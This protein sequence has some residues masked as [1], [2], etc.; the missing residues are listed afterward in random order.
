MENGAESQFE[1]DFVKIFFLL[2]LINTLK[3]SFSL[4]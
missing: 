4:L 3:A 1:D 2:V